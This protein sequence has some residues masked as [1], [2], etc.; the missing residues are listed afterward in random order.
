MRKNDNERERR[1]ETR[2]ERERGYS[3]KEREGER[4]YSEK[5]RGKRGLMRK[6]RREREKSDCR[7]NCFAILIY[8]VL[9][10]SLDIPFLVLINGFR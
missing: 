7:E 8:I 2:K 10:Q 1:R 9:S 5:E 4:G 6:K 3:K